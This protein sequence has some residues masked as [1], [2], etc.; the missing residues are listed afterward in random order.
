MID[1]QSLTKRF[2]HFTAVDR[3]SFHVGKGEIVGFLGANGA[4]KTTTMRMLAGFFPPTAG[5]AVIDGFDV[6]KQPLEV[7]RRIG[8]LPEVPPLYSEM[9]V[10][11]YLHFAGKLRGL[12]G[13]RLIGR[14]NYVCDR[15][16]ISDVRS[17]ILK[18]LSKSYRHR[19]GLAQAIVHNPQVLI[20]DEPTAGLDPE[21]TNETRTLIRSLAGDHTI[22]LSTH[23]LSEVEQTCD[24]ILVID[25]GKMVAT[26]SIQALRARS[27]GGELLQVEA[28]HHGRGIT[29]DLLLQKLENIEG[30]VQMTTSTHDAERLVVFLTRA[31]DD[32]TR[33]DI[34][35][36]VVEAGWDLIELRNT[37]TTLEGIFL[38]LTHSS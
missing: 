12:I 36:T 5:H 32:S 7:K 10:D 9:T 27:L 1:V 22:L 16:S 23:Q 17:R 35:R 30:V 18:T 21:Q 14:V 37:S 38:D 26:D 20:L 34:A 13:P 6:T 19:I 29:V 11:S 15:C 3:I 8:Y 24:H 4:G 25:R 2:A 33:G 31:S 28:V